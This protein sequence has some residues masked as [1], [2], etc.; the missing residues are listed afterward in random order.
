MQNKIFCLV[1]TCLLMGCTD[2]Q[3]MDRVLSEPGT[4]RKAVPYE[5]M[6]TSSSSLDVHL[7][8]SLAQRGWRVVGMDRNVLILERHK[9]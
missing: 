6:I 2:I 1:F 5:Y 7:L 8:N 3:P 4:D 9:D